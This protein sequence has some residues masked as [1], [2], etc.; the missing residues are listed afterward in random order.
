MSKVAAAQRYALRRVN[1][2]VGVQQVLDTGI[3]RATSVDGTHWDLEI[4]TDRPRV[5]GGLERDITGRAYIRFGLWSP[6]DGHVIAASRKL[7]K[8]DAELSDKSARLIGAL[9][10][11]QAELPF[12]LADARELWLFDE[13]G[14]SP[15]ALLA[16]LPPGSRLAVRE[17]R[18]WQCSPSARGA[19]GQSRFEE[20][21]DLEQQVRRRAGYNV[22]KCWITRQAD[23]DGVRQSDGARLEAAAFPRLLI[24]EDWGD[25]QA[26]ALVRR[27]LSW[28]APSLLTL[29]SLADSE[30]EWLERQ[31]HHQASAVE[32]HWQLY[33]K[34]L[35]P[36]RINAAR[37][38]SRMM[39]GHHGLR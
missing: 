21:R 33:P 27:Y 23:G 34:V 28:I 9:L 20:A 25:A 38:Q 19:K 22:R 10:E 17:P 8:Q 24:R 15:L 12:A 35:S 36:K 39:R 32:H 3:G 31:L 29:T 30:R 7:L 37:V 4:T 5:L 6:A 26:D 16:T 2:F 13:R 14:D 11:H 18:A 1:P